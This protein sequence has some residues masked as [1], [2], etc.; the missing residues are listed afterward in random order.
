M[1]LPLPQ[2]NPINL[3]NT[4]NI[5]RYGG[6]TPTQM[7]NTGGGIDWRKLLTTPEVLGTAITVGGGLLAGDPDDENR[8]AAEASVISNYLQNR[9]TDQLTRDKSLADFNP[10]VDQANYQQSLIR[11]AL[12]RNAR[13]F[14]F[15]NLPPEIASSM[16]QLSGGMRIPEGG[17]PNVLSDEDIKKAYLAR[18]MDRQ[19]VNPYAANATNDPQLQQY[20]QQALARLEGQRNQDQSLVM[21]ALGMGDAPGAA[22]GGKPTQAAP[23]GYEYKLNKKT[24]QYELKKKGGFWSKF[25]KIAGI[26]GAGIATALTAGSASPLLAAAVG[27]GSGAATGALSGGGWK[28][29]LTGAALGGVGGWGLGKV[30]GIPGLGF[31]G[32]TGSKIAQGVINQAPNIIGQVNPRAGQIAGTV[33]QALGG[34]HIPQDFGIGGGLP[35]NQKYQQRYPW[36]TPPFILN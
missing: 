18:Q 11:A 3:G 34:F 24:G 1:P 4:G 8:R 21:N 25:G 23:K 16:P 30:G 6:F 32:S 35:Q 13:P 20:S 31:G 19:Q 15:N 5:T 26:A 9:Q 22:T 2:V 27:A 28:G 33:Q 29:A 7:P 12:Q 14:E 10:M 36:Q 17:L